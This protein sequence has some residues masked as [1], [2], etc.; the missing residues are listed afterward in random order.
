MIPLF[1]S[2]DILHDNGYSTGCIKQ[3]S[4]DET[5][6]QSGLLTGIPEFCGYKSAPHFREIILKLL[7]DKGEL[8]LTIPDKPSSP[9]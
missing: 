2:N 1:S 4:A 3:R 9:K 6:T 8:K 7:L 5:K